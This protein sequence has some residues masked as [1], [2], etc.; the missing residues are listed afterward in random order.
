M[1]KISTG[2]KQWYESDSAY[3]ILILRLGQRRRSNFL[4]CSQMVRIF[5]SWEN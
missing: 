2:R 3:S 4:A 1:P 5:L